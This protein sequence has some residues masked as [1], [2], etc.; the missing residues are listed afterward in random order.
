MCVQE[1]EEAE[2]GTVR[3]IKLDELDYIGGE[4][5]AAPAPAPGPA[6]RGA[7]DPEENGKPAEAAA[8]APCENGWYLFCKFIERAM[9]LM[10]YFTIILKH[11][12]SVCILFG[13]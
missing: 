10:L 12:H 1:T 6:E 5:P 11:K 3:E 7:G 2:A 13:S 9:E 4:S 8:A